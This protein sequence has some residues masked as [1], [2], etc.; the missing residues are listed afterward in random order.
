M[1]SYLTYHDFISY[2]QCFKSVHT[3]FRNHL[4]IHTLL[5]IH[6]NLH[7]LLTIGIH[8]LFTIQISYLIE[9]PLHIKIIL[10]LNWPI[11]ICLDSIRI[12]PW[13]ILTMYTL[14]KVVWKMYLIDYM[15]PLC[16]RQKNLKSRNKNLPIIH[17]Q[18]DSKTTIL[19]VE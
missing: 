12:S 7:S 5:I 1:D 19:K 15:K 18:T 17:G 10:A 3:L 6:S 2:S 13:I 14:V 8:T 9:Q 4:F 16:W 11:G